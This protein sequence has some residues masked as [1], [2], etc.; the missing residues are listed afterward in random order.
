M[1]R[2]H[3]QGRGGRAGRQPVDVNAPPLRLRGEGGRAG[4][5]VDRGL[6]RAA[7]RKLTHLGEQLQPGKGGIHRVFGQHFH[8]PFMRAVVVVV[9]LLLLFGV[10]VDATAA[11]AAAV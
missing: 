7:A 10:V 11:A 9:V 5:P 6:H 3:R 1:L 2:R 8:A 4:R